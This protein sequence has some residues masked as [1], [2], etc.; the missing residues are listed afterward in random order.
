MKIN[1]DKPLSMPWLLVALVALQIPETT[2]AATVYTSRAA[3]L[4]DLAGLAP[5]TLDFEAETAG[6]VYAD[7]TT[8]AGIT[9]SGYGTPSLIVDDTYEASS[10]VNYL[11]VNNAGT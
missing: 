11:G 10:G 7:P 5:Q 4:A 3:F 9:F 6:T 8:I 2:S 1:L